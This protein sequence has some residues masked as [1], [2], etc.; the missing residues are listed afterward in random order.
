MNSWCPVL[1]VFIL[2]GMT[3]ASYQKIDDTLVWQLL[4]A[5]SQTPTAEAFDR[6]AR[7][8]T[9]AD[10][11]AVLLHDT[12]GWRPTAHYTFTDDAAY[13]FDLYLPVCTAPDNRP[14]VIA[15]LG[16]S[17]DGRIATESGASCYVTGPAN[18]TH[19]HRL[20][21]LCDAVIVG[22]AT[23]QCDNPRLTTR[24]VSGS[25][26]VRVILDPGARLGDDYG[27]FQDGETRTLVIRTGPDR[28]PDRL[29]Q[30]EVVT[31]ANDGNDHLSLPALIDE[32]Y[33][34]GLHRLFIEGGGV[35]VSRFLEQDL[36]DRLHLAVA[37]M[38]I[39]S[40]RQGLTLPP[41]DNLDNAIRPPCRQFA[42]GQ[43]VLFDLQFTPTR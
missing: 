23:V 31:I 10:P 5:L 2:S 12:P 43:D 25:H 28:Q 42:M 33:R 41:I 8:V 36:L 32:L 38:I 1:Q 29:G 24:Q 19:L 18:I 21:A 17:L 16:Q 35:T 14:F 3:I 27:V 7:P 40:G 13:L 4:L 34:R 20:R 22:A 39:G 6:Q 37:P 15:H 9:G 11:D 30:A 26:P